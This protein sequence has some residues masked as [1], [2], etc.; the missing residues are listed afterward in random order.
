MSEPFY[1]ASV[2]FGDADGEWA[3]GQIP[4]EHL[5]AI[6]FWRINAER[7]R[8]E[9]YYPDN[10]D[11]INIFSPFQLETVTEVGFSFRGPADAFRNAFGIDPEGVPA[12]VAYPD[13]LVDAGDVA[14]ELAIGLQPVGP[15]TRRT[16]LTGLGAMGVIACTDGP[17]PDPDDPTG[18]TGQTGAETGMYTRLPSGC[19]D[20]ARLPWPTRTDEIPEALGLVDT[21]ADGFR[22][23][24]GLVAVVDSGVLPPAGSGPWLQTLAVGGLTPTEDEL[25]HGTAVIEHLRATAPDVEVRSIKCIDRSGWANFPVAGFQLALERNVRQPDVVLCSWVLL[26]LS[27]ALPREIANALAR[28]VVVVF[29]AGNGQMRD[30]SAADATLPVPPESTLPEEIQLEVSNASF[31]DRTVHAIAHPDALVVG[32][33]VAYCNDDGVLE[34]QNVATA[35]DSALY[36]PDNLAMDFAGARPVPDVCGLVAPLPLAGDAPVLTETRTAPDSVL[37]RKPDGTPSDNGTVITSGSSMAAAHVAGVAAILRQAV[38]VL[39]ARAVKNVLITTASNPTWRPRSGWGLVRAATQIAAG[40]KPTALTWLEP[41][42]APFIR[43]RIDDLGVALPR[44]VDTDS[45]GFPTSPDL[46]LRDDD[47]QLSPNTRFGLVAKHI[48][49]S[50][51]HASDGARFLYVRVTN[52][53]QQP[54]SNV[55]TLYVALPTAEVQTVRVVEFDQRDVEVDPGDFVVLPL[56]ELPADARGVIIELADS[57]AS[58]VMTGNRTLTE[59]RGWVE[60]NL[61][62][63]IQTLPGGA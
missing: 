11:Y 22:G 34:E 6:D 7:I 47:T 49:G 9:P 37:D 26:E 20:G 27:V 18:T 57:T 28:D 54:Y 14:F 63:A 45:D 50:R 41:V 29:A 53:G 32:G 39:S 3:D 35:Y 16:V 51:L 62:V 56:V 2:I 4:L 31:G 25:G 48:T 33:L 13:T 36:G 46:F 52:R 55:A 59:L 61:T 17:L 38:P 44:D 43:S 23:R 10:P 24:S 15:P 42:A 58:V 19:E 8:S 12:I 40:D 1:M 60:N 21:H 5:S 30:I